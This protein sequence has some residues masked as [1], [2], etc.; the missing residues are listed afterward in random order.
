[1]TADQLSPHHA[2]ALAEAVA[3]FRDDPSVLA[4]LFGGSTARGHARPDSD[5]DLMVVVTA[6]EFARRTAERDVEVV[7]GLDHH[8]AGGYFDAKVIDVA[9]LKDVDERGSETARWAFTGVRLVHGGTAE[10]EGLVDRIPV[11]PEAARDENILDFLAQVMLLRWFVGEAVKRDD[12]YLLSYST[13][14][15]GLYAGRVFLS[16]NRM[17]FPFHKWFLAEVERAPDRPADL[18]DLIRA[19]VSRPGIDTSEAL[20]AAVLGHRDWG[21]DHHQAAARFIRNTEWPWRFGP[22]ALEDR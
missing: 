1:M 2:A 19:A 5:I 8:Y 16:W 15:L 13:S 9:F 14:R 22:P 6:E 3:S 20:A 7:R 11:F 4:V 18:P 12:P 10:I 21:L 17:L